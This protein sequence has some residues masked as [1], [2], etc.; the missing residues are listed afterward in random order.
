MAISKKTL[1]K[2]ASLA[3]IEVAKLNEAI[4]AS[5]EVDIEIPENLISMTTEEQTQRDTNM[6]AEGKKQHEQ[7]GE[8]KGKELATKAIR[9]KLGIT[10]DTKDPEKLAEIIQSKMTGDNSLKDQVTVLQKTVS[11]KDAE[12]QS[13]NARIKS[14]GTDMELIASLPGNRAKIL[15][16]TE[17]LTLIKKNL[18]ITPEGIKM[19]GELLRRPNTAEPMSLKEAV[20]KF[21][22]SRKGLIE[23]AAAGGSGGGRGAGDSGGGAGPVKTLKDVRKEF[24]AQNPKINWGGVESQTYLREVLKKNPDLVMEDDGKD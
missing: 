23:E 9:T 15:D 20:E 22:S 8:I 18:E 14:A 2:I 12:I 10:D 7:T 1:D 21:Y 4:L 17:H 16:D 13:L 19:N 11:E 3:K 5:G 24:A 6:K